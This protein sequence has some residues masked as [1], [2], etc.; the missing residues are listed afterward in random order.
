MNM[1]VRINDKYKYCRKSIMLITNINASNQ[2]VINVTVRSNVD[3]IDIVDKLCLV[4]THSLNTC[5]QRMIQSQRSNDVSYKYYS[6]SYNSNNCNS[7]NC[8][9]MKCIKLLVLT[10]SMHDIKVKIAST[11]MRS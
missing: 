11:I 6:N 9:N 7:N 4:L 1:I 3:F 10:L 5:M 8:N 2:V